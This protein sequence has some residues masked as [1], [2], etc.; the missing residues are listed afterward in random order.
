[1]DDGGGAVAAWES[2]RLMRKLGL[3]PRRTVRV[4]LWTN[5]ENGLAGALGYERRH[6]GEL[7]RH[8]LAIESDRG[9]FKPEG[10]SFVGGDAARATVK[11]LA[12][13]LARIGAGQILNQGS[14]ADVGILGHDG[15]PTMA[16]LDDGAKYFWY[17]HT[18]ADTMDKLN[19][20]ELSA[21]VAALAAMAWQVADAPLP[22]PREETAMPKK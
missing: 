1:M 22:L 21:C 18:D 9:T 2:A 19:P 20:S 12:A 13:P 7:A 4:V 8:V 6:K 10:F 3:R 17:H 14:E 15:V 11:A 16:L 5:E